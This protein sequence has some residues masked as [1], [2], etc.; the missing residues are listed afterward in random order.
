MPQTRKTSNLNHIAALVFG[1]PW[2]I[3]PADMDVI[4]G[5]VSLYLA[6][7]KPTASEAQEAA[8][9]RQY[10]AARTGED[11]SA[12]VQ[13]VRVIPLHGT[14]S[15]RA[16]SFDLMSG[17][18][19]PQQFA[20]QVRAAADDPNVTEIILDVDSGGGTVA[21]TQQ[22]YQA[23]QYAV[24]RK[25]VTAVCNGAA[26]S[27][28][29]WAIS[30]SSSIVTTGTA[31]VG[32]IGIL[33]AWRD[34]S[35]KFEQEGVT[36]HYYRS[37]DQ[38]ALG[39]PGEP[40]TEALD[41]TLRDT[42]DEMF[43]VFLDDVAAARGMTPAQ[44][45]A[46]WGSG[47]T[48][49]GQAAVTVGLADRLGTLQGEIDRAVSGQK[50]N[51]PLR[52]AALAPPGDYLVASIIQPTTNAQTPEQ[53]L[54]VQPVAPSPA[55]A[56]AETPGGAPVPPE[57]LAML[58]LKADATPEQIQ[59]AIKTQRETAAAAERTN[60]LAA[61][62]ITEEPGKPVDFAALAAR[63]ADGTAYRDALLGQIGALTI[64]TTGNDE[65]GQQAAERQK[66]VWANAD[67]TD[68]QAE[69]KRLEGVRDGQF[70]NAQ[71]SKSGDGKK[72]VPVRPFYGRR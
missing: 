14:I 61:L 36:P 21:G 49:I 46:K 22:M 33:A 24:G 53:V 43:Q 23:V 42:V 11:T 51:T 9:S 28:A 64:T 45:R 57:V 29:Y 60:I 12:A 3:L 27:A 48:W 13:T 55:P 10:G 63:A 58:G 39:G 18:T 26:C 31:E 25:P 34:A 41:A 67:I 15:N 70:P 2:A 1:R 66:R 69:V 71:L 32:S 50:P 68:L 16:D 19:S 20:R 38:K 44:A 40:M 59:A 62:G 54:G 8:A 30:P 47:R 4:A 72:A 5:V 65:A 7:E 56:R 35:K 17:G 6:G 37:G 52:T